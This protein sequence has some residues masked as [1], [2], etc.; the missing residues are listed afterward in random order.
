MPG[1]HLVVSHWISVGRHSSWERE[2]VFSNGNGLG[3]A[4]PRK[5]REGDGIRKGGG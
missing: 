2:E 3:V 5:E 1:R 4:N